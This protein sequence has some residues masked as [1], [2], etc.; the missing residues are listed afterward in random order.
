MR[1]LI[2]NF[3]AFDARESYIAKTPF[4]SCVT[5]NK[6]LTLVF[7]DLDYFKPDQII[8]C[9]IKEC[10]ILRKLYDIFGAKC[11]ISIF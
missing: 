11:D 7:S 6:T 9:K 8:D 4:F 1:A 10:V 3:V 5:Y 2:E